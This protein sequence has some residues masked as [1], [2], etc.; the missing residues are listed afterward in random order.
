[1]RGD[2]LRPLL[3]P[4]SHTAKPWRSCG[5]RHVWSKAPTRR[6]AHQLRISE[7]KIRGVG[8]L[9]SK[10]HSRG[11]ICIQTSLSCREKKPTPAA[12]LQG[13]SGERGG[14]ALPSAGR[15]APLTFAGDAV[16]VAELVASPTVTLVG[17]VHVGAFLAAGTA[18]TLVHV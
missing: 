10:P 6:G 13:C 16:H 15:G 14:G 2:P 3:A 18:V 5:P 12:S 1:M 8:V 7:R 17:A 4:G 9:F 11:L